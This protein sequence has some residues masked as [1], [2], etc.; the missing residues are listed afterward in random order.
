MILNQDNI[1]KISTNEIYNFIKYKLD[2]IY[3]S[4]KYTGIT[5]DEFDEIV[6]N[7]IDKS[8]KITIVN[9]DYS[10]YII[11][12]VQGSISGY[13]FMLINNSNTS[14]QLIDNYINYHFN[15]EISSIIA[16]NYFSKLNTFFE[17]NN[18]MP[19]QDIIIKLIDNNSIFY[20]MIV[21][22]I[23]QNNTISEL[24]KSIDS[25][26]LLV[27]AIETF[28]M[29]KNISIVEDKE[30]I[31]HETFSDDNVSTYINEIS[32]IPLLTF[33]EEKELAYKIKQGD[34]D[35][36]EKF[37]ES[38]LR[39]VLKIAY[40]YSNRGLSLLDLIQEGNIGLIKAVNKFDVEKGY[41]FS[42]FATYWVRQAMQRA[43]AN[44]SRNIRI[45]AYLY[46]KLYVYKYTM[47]NLSDKLNRQPTTEEIAQEM[48]ITVEQVIAI[49][50]ISMDTIS[51]NIVVGDKEENE[52]GNLISSDEDSIE[53]KLDKEELNKYLEYILNCKLKEREREIIKYRF[54]FYDEK[55]M[56]LDELG[57]KYNITRE[58]IRQIEKRVLRKIRIYLLKSKNGLVNDYINN[59]NDLNDTLIKE[60]N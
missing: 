38:N 15:E 8:K 45:P 57:K 22:V 10:K 26:D 52:L 32:K 47:N 1:N 4:I 43:L 55:I 30:K 36:K 6:L 13:I 28:C 5:K 14:Y 7:E 39:L 24:L 59:S 49:S 18:Y 17:K 60:K 16:L 58:A 46:D 37:I 42:T 51:T 27:N 19:N 41:K 23:N 54:G 29:L 35:A 25:N 21:E 53:E 20:K 44:K 34:K 31:D 3:K 33:D 48:N 40:W 12:R 11:K 50:K 2:S 56:T 9:L